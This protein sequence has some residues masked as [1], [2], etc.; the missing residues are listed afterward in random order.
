MNESTHIFVD[1]M[2]EQSATAAATG[3][4]EF[5]EAFSLHHRTV[6]RAARSVVQD[7]ALA[8]DVTQETFLRLYHNLDSITDEEM[9]RPWLIRVAINVARN[10]IRG[11]IRANT[12]NENYVKETGTLAAASVETDYEENA[13][14]SD[15][16][17]ALNK[18]KEPLRSCLIL[19]QQGLSYKE[20]ARSLELN[21]SSIGTFVARARQEFSRF[22]GKIGKDTL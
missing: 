15:I 7:P 8:E 19:K 2:S 22:Y 9:L 10:T 21:E 18:I 4:I 16:Y 5:E 13:G 20:I 6:F 3:R 14:V 12:R 1:I 11:T 17:K